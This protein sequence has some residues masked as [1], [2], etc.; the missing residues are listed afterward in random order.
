MVSIKDV[1]ALAG[2]SDRTVSRVASGETKLISPKT[3]RKVLKAIEK[4]GYVPNRAARMTRTGRSQ[5]IG[6]M[7]DVVATT[8]F[9]TD[10]VRGIQDALD[11]TPYTLLTINTAGDPAKEA[12]SWQT[13]R[14]H[15]ID[16]ALYVTMFH[17]HLPATIQLPE[18]PVVLV[19]C[20]LPDRSEVPAIVPD[21][22]GGGLAL[23]NHLLARGHRRLAYVTLNPNI[24]AAE[25]RE[26]AFRDA[27]ATRG[28]AVREEWVVP[29]LV[30]EVFNDRFVA[31]EN[32]TQILRQTDRPTAIVAGND[33]IALQCYCAAMQLGLR[34]PHDISIVGFD[35]FQAVSNVVQPSLTTMALPYQAMGRRAVEV[36]LRLLA[37][38]KP[39]APLDSQ[40]CEL[41]E[42]LSV[43]AV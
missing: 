43:K 13:F 35:D 29:G 21:D 10:I 34:V 27:H 37:G 28:L 33:E 18:S 17:R 38:D 19:N 31:F 40:P 30:G 14:E 23:V 7:T 39:A 20:A 15:G 16:G 8:P 3:R 25:L 22:Y 1:A 24:L 42:R 5:V 26:R 36:L 4:L 2:V 32:V 12:R 11:S 41:V 9:S 6:L